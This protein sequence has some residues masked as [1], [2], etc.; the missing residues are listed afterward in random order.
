MKN[1]Q[2]LQLAKQ[3]LVFDGLVWY[4]PATRK[5][6]TCQATHAD[7]ATINWASLGCGLVATSWIAGK[8][9]LKALCP[10]HST[11]KG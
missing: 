5:S 8:Y 1:I 6:A 11:N 3:G 4:D 2:A 7:D 9:N 10:K